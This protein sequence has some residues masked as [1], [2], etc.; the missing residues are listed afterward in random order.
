MT[1]SAGEPDSFLQGRVSRSGFVAGYWLRPK[2][3]HGLSVVVFESEQAARAA[4]V[5]QFGRLPRTEERPS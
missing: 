4:D 3:G 1:T 2:D 5:D